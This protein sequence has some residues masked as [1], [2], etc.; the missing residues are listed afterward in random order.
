MSPE[1]VNLD[2][3]VDAPV[4]EDHCYSMPTLIGRVRNPT[5]EDGKGKAD[6]ELAYISEEDKRR[7]ALIEANIYTE[8]SVGLTVQRMVLVEDSEDGLPVYRA[9]EWTGFEVSVTPLPADPDAKFNRHRGSKMALP[10]EIEKDV[11]ALVQR[12]I[13]EAMPAPDEPEKKPPVTRER[14]SASAVKSARELGLSGDVILS[15]I[16]KAETADNPENEFHKLVR[17][18]LVEKQRPIEAS[19]DPLASEGLPRMYA[20][21]RA[22]LIVRHKPELLDDSEEGKLVKQVFQGARAKHLIPM[23]VM[24]DKICRTAGVDTSNYYE[25]V[26]LMI[27]AAE[28]QLSRQHLRRDHSRAG[29]AVYV[30][31]GGGGGGLVTPGDVKSLLADVIH[32]IV[33]MAYSPDDLPFTSIATRRDVMDTHEHNIVYIDVA[34]SLQKK[35]VA[36]GKLERLVVVES[37]GTFDAEL[38]GATLGIDWHSLINDRFDALLR[39][40]AQI[41]NLAL[42]AQ[43]DILA[44]IIDA[45]VFNNGDPVFTEAAGN[46]INITDFA[47]GTD[48]EVYRTPAW[49]ARNF[50]LKKN[51]ARIDN[52]V[53]PAVKRARTRLLAPRRLVHDIDQT[54]RLQK[55]FQQISTPASREDANL[56]FE[57]IIN[58]GL[59]EV[60]GLPA[61]E[62]YYLL[63]EGNTEWSPLVVSFISGQEMRTTL[64]DTPVDEADGFV[65]KILHTFGAAWVNNS[66]VKVQQT[67][68]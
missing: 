37:K 67:P 50:L 68:A 13:A 36:G 11:N 31:H 45:G 26:D 8:L 23:K 48:E 41:G 57:R 63:P 65:T 39:L 9:V 66:A 15:V 62:R 58:S 22:A 49:Q 53:N 60:L 40:P 2:R 18:A 55:T 56:D 6:F 61:E 27:A 51:P 47:G 35:I 44:D 5:L 42:S 7:V 54:R 30:R 46:L 64:H 21:V 59:V 43:W 12:A 1:A 16:D 19:E 20:A 28:T 32:T 10:P 3:M 14:V 33:V 29:K 17:E 52:D 4:F 34:G 24:A 38:Y 25:P